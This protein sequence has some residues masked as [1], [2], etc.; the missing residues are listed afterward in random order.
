M[1]VFDFDGT[2]VDSNPIKIEAFA[3]CFADYPNQFEAIMAY[4]RENHHTPRFA[5][6]R[7]V[8]EHI[9]KKPYTPA[10]EKTLLQR[11]EAETTQRIIDAP[12][13]PNAMALLRRWVNQ[14]ELVLLSSTPHAILLQI[15]EQRKMRDY[16][17]IIR[18]APVDKASW[19]IGFYQGRSLLP[20]EVVFIG[21]TQ[22]DEQS[23]KAAG[24]HFL[25]A[26]EGGLF[27]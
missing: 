19:L 12:E 9:L 18:G 11:Y 1:L 5:K 24:V 26:A 7:H 4:C 2:L 22:E 10:I 27:L 16:F 25:S 21:D 6:F 13:I 17:S 23:A 20:E 8:F 3:K 14:K 15:L